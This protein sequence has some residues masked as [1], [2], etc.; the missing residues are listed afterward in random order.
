MFILYTVY[1]ICLHETCDDYLVR[2]LF[3]LKVDLK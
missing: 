3:A 2:M 1:W